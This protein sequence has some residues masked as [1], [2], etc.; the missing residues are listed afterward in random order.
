M[1]LNTCYNVGDFLEFNGKQMKIIS[2][3]LYESEFCHTERY[4]LGYGKRITLE[5]RRNDSK[6]TIGTSGCE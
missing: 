6:R 3:H 2:I 5:R 4:Y 1:K